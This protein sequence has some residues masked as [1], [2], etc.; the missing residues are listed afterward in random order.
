[1]INLREYQSSAIDSIRNGFTTDFRQYI[2]MPTGSGKTVTFLTYA[3]RNH[4]RILIIVPSREILKQIYQ[5]C[6][7]FYEKNN[8]S[9]KGDRYNEEIQNVHI[10]IINSLKGFYLDNLINRNFDLIIID[11]A[12]HAQS[13]SYITF[14]NKRCAVFPNQKILGVTATPDRLDGKFLNEILYK[15]SFKLE[16]EDLI[17]KKHLSEVEGFSLKSKIDISELAH[18]NGDFNLS[19]LF[20]KLCVDSRNKMILNLCQNE[21][22]ERK[23]LIFC[24][25]IE[26]SKII[27]KIL[28]ENGI[29]SSHI[30]GSMKP[31]KRFS[32]LSSFRNGEIS[33]L[34]NCQLLIEG[35]DE[36]SIDGII[37][38]RPTKSRSLFLQMIGRGLRI[39]PGKIN[40]KIIDIVDNHKSLSGFN[41][42]ITDSIYPELTSFRSI[43]D[44]R[45]H[46]NDENLK[47]TEITLEKIN[48]FNI[49]TID[50]EATDG[51][52]KYLEDSNIVF[53]HPIS[54]NEASFLI[55]HNELKKEYYN[56]KN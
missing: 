36:P 32:I 40:C 11:E 27:S 23:T 20:K 47:L 19:H 3:H 48:L 43:K 38:A 2:E 24:I 5:T 37:L 54:F 25:N 14:I 53:F 16:I 55:W 52:V 56:V 51:M 44:I 4:Q 41:S 18:N 46:I 17:E 13:K 12:H 29:S 28:N 45:N 26:H 30:D 34:T 22:Q 9:R 10:C 21:M 15:C 50:E 39:N 33:V 6:L 35:F 31:D 42:L 49:T 1:M 8:I 7:V